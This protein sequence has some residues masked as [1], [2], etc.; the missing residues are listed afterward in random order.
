MFT[1]QPGSDLVAKPLHV[2][3]FMVWFSSYRIY[4]EVFI[5]TNV[6]VMNREFFR[7]VMNYFVCS[8]SQM[9]HFWLYP[10]VLTA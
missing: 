4:M 3:P 10:V 8:F 1:F 5:R 2:S 9:K 7:Q 6:G